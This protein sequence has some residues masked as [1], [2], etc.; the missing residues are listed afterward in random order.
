MTPGIIYSYVNHVGDVSLCVLRDGKVRELV[1]SGGYI[2]AW[3]PVALEKW[4][5]M[6][7]VTGTMADE[8]ALLTWMVGA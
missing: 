8:G 2:H 5:A 1:A 4:A 6:H 7:V 3:K